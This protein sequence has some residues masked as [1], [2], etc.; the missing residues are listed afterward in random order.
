V[1]GEGE[2]RFGKILVIE[3]GRPGTGKLVDET[4]KQF[5]EHCRPAS[6]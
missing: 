5:R 4:W 2:V 3:D 6:Q 1:T